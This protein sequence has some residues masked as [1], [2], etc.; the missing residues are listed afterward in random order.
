M[1]IPKIDYK[2]DESLTELFERNREIVFDRFFECISFG[3]DNDI[4]DVIVFEL[5]ETGFYLEANIADWTV[6]LECCITYFSMIENY[7]KCI[8]CKKLINEIEQ[9][10][11]N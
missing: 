10:T 7:E 1:K 11:K 9:R 6:S 5:G 2:P 3:L 4:N 8:D